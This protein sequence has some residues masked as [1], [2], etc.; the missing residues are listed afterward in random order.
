[1]STHTNTHTHK[2]TYTTTNN[3]KITE[4]SNHWSLIS[5]TIY[6]FDSLI[7]KNIK[8]NKRN[9]KPGHTPLLHMRKIPQRKRLS[10]SKRLEKL[11]VSFFFF[12]KKMNTRKKLVLLF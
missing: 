1:M 7:K 8:A 4:I 11:F 12:F 3:I 5:F 9:V 10:P 6:R 2:H